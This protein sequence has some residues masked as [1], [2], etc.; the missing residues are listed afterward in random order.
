MFALPE[1][2]VGLAALAGGLQRLPRMIGLKRSMGMLL[3]GRRVSAIEGRELGFVNEVAE[4]DV[5]TAARR[6]AEEILASSPLSVRATKQAVLRGLDTPI[7]KALA[8]EWD[9]PAVRQMLESDDAIE[10]PRA[11]A[12]K[13]LPQWSGH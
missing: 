6:W 7:E 10:G 11:F 9:Y 4:D 5:L 8:E 2:K 3:T 12:E 1:P 13:R